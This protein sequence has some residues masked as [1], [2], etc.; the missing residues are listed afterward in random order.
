MFGGR[1]LNARYVNL[2]LR[3]ISLANYS[4]SND[5]LS[6]RSYFQ[7]K[8]GTF[9]RHPVEFYTDLYT[10]IERFTTYASFHGSL[11]HHFSMFHFAFFIQF[12]NVS[13]DKGHTAERLK[14]EYLTA[15]ENFNKTQTLFYEADLPKIIDVSILL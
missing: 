7:S 6:L 15:L 8:G 11:F 13:K 1:F 3:L 14:T 9:L 5:I 12:Q 2:S 4:E 10:S